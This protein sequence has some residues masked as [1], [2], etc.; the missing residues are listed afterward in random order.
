MI[1]AEIIAIDGLKKGSIELP[2]IF[3]SEVRLDLIKRAYDAEQSVK[4]PKYGAFRWAGQQTSAPKQMKHARAGYK[5]HYGQGIS[6]FP[7]KSL[8]NRGSRFFWVGA[9]APGARGGRGAHPAKPYK[10]YEKSIN[11][12]EKKKAFYSVI[13][14]SRIMVIEN[15]F[16]DLKKTKEILNAIKNITK[17]KCLIVTSKDIKTKNLDTKMVPVKQISV[18]DLAPGSIPRKLVLWTE[19]AIME[20]K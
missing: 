17:E 19:K 10:N 11:Q 9:F 6:R 15:K 13:S 4:R 14:A 12:K 3:E 1:K 18:S 2:K 8:S 16:E 20:V 7:R 5:A